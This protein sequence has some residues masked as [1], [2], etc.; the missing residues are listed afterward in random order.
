[1]VYIFVD[2]ETITKTKQWSLAWRPPTLHYIHITGLLHINESD[3]KSLTVTSVLRLLEDQGN[4][5]GAII[6]QYKQ[7]VNRKTII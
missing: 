7:F 2:Q 3:V 1:M 4:R 5:Q 6:S